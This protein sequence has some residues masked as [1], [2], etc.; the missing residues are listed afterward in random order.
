MLM[1]EALMLRVP[2]LKRKSYFLDERAL[3]R[4]RRALGA[5]S[6]AETIRLALQRIVE[7][8]DFWRF[9]DRTRNRLKPGS[10]DTP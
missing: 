1:G 6:D 5:P 8:E 7:M 9:M 4:A 10:F 3:R 2:A